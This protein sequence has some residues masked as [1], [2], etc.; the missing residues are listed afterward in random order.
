MIKT[1]RP[2]KEIQKENR[3]LLRQLKKREA[4]IPT[5]QSESELANITRQTVFNHVQRSKQF[6]F[7]KRKHH[8]KWTKIILLINW[9]GVKNT[10]PG[11]LNGHPLF[12]LMRKSSI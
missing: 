9:H 10:C 2:Q 5:A 11:L 1:G 6:Q 4:N 7:T 8:P 12:S 3:N